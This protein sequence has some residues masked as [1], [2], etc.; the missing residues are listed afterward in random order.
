M[1]IP[2]H[3]HLEVDVA[4]GALGEQEPTVAGG[5]LVRLPTVGQLAPGLVQ[6]HLERGTHMYVELWHRILHSANKRREFP[7]PSDTAP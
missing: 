3:Q 4:I 2:D 1:L 6:H 7:L 5:E